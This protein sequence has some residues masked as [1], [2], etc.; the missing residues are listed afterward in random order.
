MMTMVMM[1]MMLMTMTMMRVTSHNSG[2]TR[3]IRGTPLTQ[4]PRH[5]SQRR[6]VAI[7]ASSPGLDPASTRPSAREL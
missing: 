6:G 4:P 3:A 1:M 2:K 7:P 5:A